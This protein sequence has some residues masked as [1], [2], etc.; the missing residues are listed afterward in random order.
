MDSLYREIEK[1]FSLYNEHVYV[2]LK[3]IVN[4]DKKMIDSIYASFKD[5]ENK[6]KTKIKVTENGK[7][8]KTAYQIFF[9]TKRREISEKF[10]LKKFGEISKEISLEWKSMSKEEKDCF[11]DTSFV[12]EQQEQQEEK[13]QIKTKK[14]GFEHFFIDDDEQLKNLKKD[15]KESQKQEIGEQDEDHDEEFEEYA[16]EHPHLEEYDSVDEDDKHEK[17][18]EI[19]I[20]TDDD[21]DENDSIG[22]D[23][24]SFNFDI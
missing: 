10:P 24:I 19:E 18:D 9:A 20:E 14:M 21:F 17:Q 2:N 23:S 8:K 3:D 1:V 13:E 15:E 12:E 4:I 5:K 16:H 6:T 7:K 22:A 11:K